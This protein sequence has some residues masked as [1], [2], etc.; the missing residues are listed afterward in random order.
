MLKEQWHIKERRVHMNKNKDTENK[1]N[2]MK[3]KEENN[4]F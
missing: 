2:R 1:N 4:E 3:G